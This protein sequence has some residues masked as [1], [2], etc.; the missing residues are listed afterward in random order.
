MKNI[1]IL[2]LLF[3]VIKNY[4]QIKIKVYYEKI[5]G[6]FVVLA[7]NDEYCPVSVK[8]DFKL[9]NL[10]SSNGNH[11]IFITPA[12]SKRNVITVLKSINEGRYRFNYKTAYNYS[13][14]FI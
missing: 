4:S 13:S 1:F 5:N 10:K 12:R 2:F 6:G 8:V 3:F 9:S 14:Y 11:K 7:D